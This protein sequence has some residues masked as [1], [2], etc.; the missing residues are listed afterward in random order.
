[1]YLD[2]ARKGLENG[3]KEDKVK[4]RNG[5]GGMERKNVGVRKKEQGETAGRKCRER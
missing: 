2:R 3:M 5:D 1:M 4:D